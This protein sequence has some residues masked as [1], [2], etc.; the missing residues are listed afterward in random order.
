MPDTVTSF[1]ARHACHNRA[2]RP[3]RM[4]Q[5]I[6]SILVLGGGSAGLLSALALTTKLPDHAVTVA[7]RVVYVVTGHMPG[8]LPV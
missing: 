8:S 4:S 2:T 3:T 5:P 6:R 7:R 1:R